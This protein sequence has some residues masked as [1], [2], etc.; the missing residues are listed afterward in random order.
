MTPISQ[1][2]RT[3]VL[4]G[5]IL[6]GAVMAA[7]PAS[8]ES[9]KVL[10]DRIAT[11]DSRLEVIAKAGKEPNWTEVSRYLGVETEVLTFR[12]G[13]SEALVVRLVLGKVV[14]VES[15][16]MMPWETR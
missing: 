15:R 6:A 3:A 13:L 14:T 2:L 5:T 16:P 4:A 12:I 10:A 8:A 1:F 7:A 11:G 9:A